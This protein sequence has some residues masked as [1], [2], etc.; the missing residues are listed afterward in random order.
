MIKKIILFA[1]ITALLFTINS[2]G[3]KSAKTEP[4]Q[5]RTAGKKG[6]DY[7]LYP[8]LPNAPRY[9]YLTTFSNSTDVVKKKSKFFKFVA[10]KDVEK[11]KEIKK[12][13]GVDIY[14]GVIYTCDMGHGVVVTIDL[15]NQLYGYLGLK[16]SGK[17]VKP[18]NIKIDRETGLIYV[19]DMGRKQVVCFNTRGEALKFYGKKEQ[20][21]PSAVDVAGTKL[22]V[23]DVRGHSIHVL[24][25][26]TGELLYKIGETGSKEGQLFHPTNIY[27][28]GDRLYVSDTSN[29]RFQVFDLKG[30][31]ISTFGEI[32][33]R[34]GNFSRPKGIAVDKNGRVYVIDAA[35]ENVQVFNKE[36]KLLLF[37]LGPGREKH[38]INLPAGIT[39]DYDN[40][41]LFKKYIAPKFKA[42]Y[43]LFVTSNFGFNKVNVYAFGNYQQ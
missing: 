42:E 6:S 20:F 25:T 12:A 27:V 37:M 18:V 31:F 13:Y 23:C 41:R 38:N 33:D 29:F 39:I 22:F 24:D 43:L 1:F 36:N 15:V 2:C 19:A 14:N 26:R 8:P 16:G 30:K 3:P 35:F 4:G 28:R 11:P 40:V 32:G 5:A 10:G 21:H 17:L 7:I 34:P 9:Q